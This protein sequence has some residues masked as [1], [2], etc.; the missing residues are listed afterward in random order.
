M[1]H[2]SRLNSLKE[3]AISRGDGSCLRQ[4][5]VKLDTDSQKLPWKSA[6]EVR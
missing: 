6:N 4:K 2:V 3:R 5:V 1:K